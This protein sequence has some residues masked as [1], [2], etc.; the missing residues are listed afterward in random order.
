MQAKENWPAVKLTDR[1]R[2][3]L[4]TGKGPFF[5]YVEQILPIVHIDHLPWWGNSFTIIRDNLHILYFSSVYPVPPILYLSTYLVD[6]VKERP[7]KVKDV[8][9]SYLLRLRA[10]VHGQTFGGKNR[11]TKPLKFVLFARSRIRILEK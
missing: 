1:H 6:V 7:P 5:H 8:S 11:P 4:R 10:A 3:L 9:P 2:R